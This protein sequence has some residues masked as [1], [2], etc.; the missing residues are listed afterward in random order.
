[1]KM[2]NVPSSPHF[3]HCPRISRISPTLSRISPTRISR[4]H[5]LLRFPNEKAS[6]NVP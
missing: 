4:N 2:V 5:A 1:M 6:R 3:P